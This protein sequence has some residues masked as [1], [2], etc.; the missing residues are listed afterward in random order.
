MKVVLI[1]ANSTD[2]DKM[3]HCIAFHLDFHCLSK[4]S[5]MGSRPQRVHVVRKHPNC[6]DETC[7]L[8]EADK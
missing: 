8:F 5:F 6:S 3:P 7:F 4:Y 2:T 1:S